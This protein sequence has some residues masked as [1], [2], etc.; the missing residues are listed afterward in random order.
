MVAVARRRHQ[1]VDLY[2]LPGNS[3]RRSQGGTCLNPQLAPV[4]TDEAQGQH[5]SQQQRPRL[6]IGLQPARDRLGPTDLF[7][8]VH[9]ERRNS[10][11]E[12]RAPRS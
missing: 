12:S 3:P 8:L 6:C 7:I 1:G 5:P 2:A 10:V 9:R 4:S 11:D